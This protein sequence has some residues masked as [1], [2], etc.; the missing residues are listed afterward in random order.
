MYWLDKVTP[1]GLSFQSK[2][3]NPR[4]SKRLSSTTLLQY[5][6]PKLG[7]NK[8]TYIEISIR[9]KLYFKSFRSRGKCKQLHWGIEQLAGSESNAYIVPRQLHLGT[10]QAHWKVKRC[11]VKRAVRN[12]HWILLTKSISE[13]PE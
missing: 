7:K 1:H 8:F 4:K 2:C 6:H 9:V 10:K 11:R 3:G 13:G 5:K 12:T